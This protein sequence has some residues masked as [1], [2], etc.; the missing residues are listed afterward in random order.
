MDQKLA[1]DLNALYRDPT[2]GYKSA[3]KFYK[4]AKAVISSILSKDSLE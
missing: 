4:Q 3:D 1:Q 2:T